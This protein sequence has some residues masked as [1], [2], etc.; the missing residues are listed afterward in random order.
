VTLTTGGGGDPDHPPAP[1]PPAE[2]EDAAMAVDG[3]RTAAHPVLAQKQKQLLYFPAASS[4][5]VG[6]RSLRS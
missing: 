3:E 4:W 5:A 2:S 1:S 6:A